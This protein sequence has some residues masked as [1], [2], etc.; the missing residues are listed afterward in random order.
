MLIQ[1]IDGIETPLAYA[2]RF[3]KGSELNYTITEKE[4]LGAVWALKKFQY[5][6]WGCQI[7]IVT[8]HHALCWLLSK[9]E[10][11]GRLARWTTVVQ[12]ENLKIIYKSGKA[13]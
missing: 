8:D 10:L 6:V 11:A 9:K 13:H 1:R 3:L 2:S 12:G 7:I 5:L 4:C